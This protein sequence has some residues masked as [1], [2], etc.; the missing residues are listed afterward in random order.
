MTTFKAAYYQSVGKAEDVLKLGRF[1]L[2][3]P[4]NNE[5]Q[6]EI[7]TSAVNPSDVKIRHGYE[8]PLRY[9]SFTPHSDGAGIV[10][11]CGSAVS[12]FKPGDRVWV[13]NAAWERNHG[14]AS[15]LINLPEEFV[16]PLPDNTSF[17]IGACLGIPALTAAAALLSLE[18]DRGDTIMITGGSGAVGMCAIQMAKMLGFKVMSTVRSQE[19]ARIATQMGADC[20]INTLTE[21]PV[22][23]IQQYTQDQLLDGIVEVDFGGN[24]NWT[25][26]ALK[27]NGIIAAYASMGQKTP[28]IDFYPMMFKQ[29]TL[30]PIFV[31]VLSKSMRAR[32]IELV[33]K[34]LEAKKLTPLIA[35]AYALDDIVEAHLA[36]EAGNK[37]GQVLIHTN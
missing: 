6:I 7:I 8:G 36:V 10:K 30:K 22:E 37:I 20:V 34:A 3:S 32:A 24:L 27:L 18:C 33:Q 4:K 17:E 23:K 35:K 9:P 16:V 28:T 21:N 19:K 26:P 11:A 1:E 29:I 31:Y 14:T 2:D 13:Y 12:Q 15:T 5:V 25:I